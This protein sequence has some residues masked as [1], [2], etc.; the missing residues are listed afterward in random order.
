VDAARKS[1]RRVVLRRV[2]ALLAGGLVLGVGVTVSLAAWNDSEYAATTVTA[3][4]FGVEGSVNGGA[5][6]EHSTSG[7][8]AALVFSPSVTQFSPGTV[9]FQSFAVRTTATSTVG[10]TVTLQQPSTTPTSGALY[11]G[12]VYAIRTV[13]SGSACNQALFANAAA[14]VIVA[15]AS[16]LGATITANPRPLS[17]ASADPVTFCV[18]IELTTST[19]TAAQ[20]TALTIQMRFLGEST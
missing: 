1:R 20:G 18:R 11:N 19:D 2:Q 8:A 7:A 12:L 9:G 14:P 10:G 4:V 5:Y 16:G 15:N 6:S 17:A 3:S 13:P